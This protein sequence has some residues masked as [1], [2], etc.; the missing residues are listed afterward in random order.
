MTK[1]DMTIKYMGIIAYIDMTEKD[2]LNKI[3]Y[4]SSKI[5]DYTIE[6]LKI[7]KKKKKKTYSNE[8]F[9]EEELNRYTDHK[10]QYYKTLTN[11]RVIAQKLIEILAE[12]NNKTEIPDDIFDE[13]F[14]LSSKI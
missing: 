2:L 9:Y 13:I 10:R 7:R 6:L 12:N 14:E 1:T 11:A 3:E 4:C 5:E 8:K